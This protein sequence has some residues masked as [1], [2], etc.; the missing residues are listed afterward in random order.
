MKRSSRRQ[1][2]LVASFVASTL[3][4]AA[5]APSVVWAQTAE[6][7]LRGHAT[8]GATITATNIATGASRRTT[9]A[10]DGSYTLA[11]MPPGTYRVNAG[12]GT[13]QVLTLSVASTETYDF[14]QN[15]AHTAELQQVVVSGT[16]LQDVRTSEVG[17]IV[18]LR[19]IETVP[20]ITRNFL[21]FAD[22][23]PGMNFTVS[24]NGDTSIRGGAE[25]DQ[26]VNVY[27][28]GVGMKDYISG[29]VSG[30]S[31][32]QKAGDPGNP[33]PQGAISEYKVITSNYSAAYDQV[34]SAAITA[35]T[36]SGS[37]DFKGETFGDFTNENLRADTPAEAA[38]TQTTNPK[39]GGAT[40]EYGIDE[41][42]PI[43]PNAMHFFVD[44]EHK[45]LSLPNSVFPAGQ[46][47]A[48]LANLQPVLPA[49]VYSQFGPTSNPFKE[50]LVFAKIDW[51]PSDNDRFEL[52]DLTR[53]E[54]QQVGAGGQV[55]VSAAYNFKDDN[56]RFMLL[57]QHAADRWINEA[58]ITYQNALDAPEQASESPASSYVYWQSTT[59]SSQ[60]LQ[61]NGQDPRSYFRYDQSGPGFQDDF[62][63]SD[64]NFAG[65]HTL[66]MGVK[67]QS[68]DLQARDASQGA[69]YY[70]AVDSTGTYS[71][72]YQALYT[73]TNPGQDITATSTD[74]QYGVYFEDD[75]VPI[76][77][78]TLNLGVRWDYETVPSWQNYQLP[79]SL[80]AAFNSPYPT[81][82]AGQ[83]QPTPG[84]TY[85]QALALG[86]ININNYIGNGHDRS[87]PTNEFQPRLGFSYDIHDD[88]RHVI[89]GGYA[90]SYDRNVF[91]VMS[92][93]TTKLAISEPTIN[94]Y[95]TPYT[96]GGCTTA[97]NASKN[98]LAWNPAYLTL[99][100]LQALAPG[101]FGEIDL[102]NN[103]LK[104]PY[105]DQF[106]LG[107]RNRL[108]DWDTSIAVA[109]IN[110]YN[111][112]LGHLG[113]RYANGAYYNNGTQWGAA[114]VPGLVGNL[115]LWDNAENDRD[116]EVLVSADKPY[117][118][119]SHWG[120]SIAYT[121][122]RAFQNNPLTYESNNGYEFDLPF[123]SDYPYLPSSAVPRHRLVITGSVDGPWGM[124][125]GAKLA[126]STPTPDAAIEGCPDP[127]E[128][129]GY[130]AYPVVGYF[131]DA[132]QQRE[133]DVQATKNFDI[134]HYLSAYV[135]LD[136]LNV[137]NTPY[138]DQGAAIFSP[139][140]GK[141]Y[142]PPMY[143]TAGP[144][145]G[146][147]LTLKITGGMKW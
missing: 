116:T 32:A 67:F 39:Q 11:G 82:A 60:V 69:D 86:G 50:D 111:G 61:V 98:C 127:S 3:A 45:D 131:R 122:S 58:R 102:T 76:P 66:K 144:I 115:V 140:P 59:V 129:H 74:K 128:C 100:N 18:S 104:N 93:E 136:I 135:R 35:V 109:Q 101:A 87:S 57:W 120:A 118:P 19:E 126:L 85:A 17:A 78:L 68:M 7:N 113:N 145:L 70:Y 73:V 83:P 34:A 56:E 97:A 5:Y 1:R 29:G 31:G 133:L 52:T 63:L 80:V 53:I 107:I 117:T 65:D 99:A 42:G 132:L 33:F 72:P 138:Y 49:S 75:W 55:A 134:T 27:I 13:A 141:S 46:N 89:F 62:T 24:S 10:L 91:D 4:A 51:E 77:K 79:A 114:G 84:E 123:P 12:P 16:R 48:T 137:L 90:R 41:G 20:Q 25:I 124:L 143:N 130:N 105:S 112:I 28:D 37:N 146:V 125:Y 6:A 92:L 81:P 95:G 94:F 44:Y 108:G 26:N 54:K 96:N 22:T 21:E 103:H 64:L 88:Q 119:E 147:P 30:Q 110:S 15:A 71:T 38:S 43:I 9:A 8:P 121:Y 106:S 14:T 36:K 40:D 23:V 142:P 2:S 47:G 139:T